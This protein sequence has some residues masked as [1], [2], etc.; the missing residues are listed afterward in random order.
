MAAHII[1]EPTLWE[2]GSRMMQAGDP[3]SWRSTI[4]AIEMRRDNP[5]AIVACEQRAA[6]SKRPVRCT[7]RIIPR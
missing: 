2:A 5:E 1:G 7:I 3:A 4:L 6:K